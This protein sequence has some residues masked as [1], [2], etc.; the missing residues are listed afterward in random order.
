MQREPN[1]KRGME[2]ALFNSAMAAKTVLIVDDEQG[3]RSVLGETLVLQ[4]WQVFAAGSAEVARHL[5]NFLIEKPSVVVT[6]VRMEN[7]LAGMTLAEEISRT[8]PETKVVVMSGHFS[9]STDFPGSLYYMPKPFSS[10]EL[11][12]F[13][14][15]VT[16]APNS[17]PELGVFGSRN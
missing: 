11:A 17:T 13:I 2:N 3:I 15:E 10:L 12:R 4:G 9:P 6:D 16:S 8:S 7:R 1:A 5:W 14:A